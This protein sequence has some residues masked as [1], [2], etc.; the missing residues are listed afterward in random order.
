MNQLFNRLHMAI[1]DDDMQQCLTDTS[2]FDAVDDKNFKVPCKAH[3]LESALQL[4]GDLRRQ[5]SE[6]RLAQ[7]LEVKPSK[8]AEPT[9]PAFDIQLSTQLSYTL[10]YNDVIG[11]YLNGSADTV[12]PEGEAMTAD[13]ATSLTMGCE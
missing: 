7:A 8:T 1:A 12:M 10:S 4:I 3:V 13:L 6:E 11:D 2:A 5:L 9:G